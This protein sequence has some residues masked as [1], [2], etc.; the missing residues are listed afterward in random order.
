MA[1]IP[2]VSPRLFRTFS[3]RPSS[4]AARKAAFFSQLPRPAL[5]VAVL[6]TEETEDAM[7]GIADDRLWTNRY[8][9]ETGMLY[10]TN[11]W[12]TAYEAPKM[13]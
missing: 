1:S 11:K 8:G 9:D 7:D 3:A 2:N 5:A 13:N 10:A 12:A 6:T 4:P